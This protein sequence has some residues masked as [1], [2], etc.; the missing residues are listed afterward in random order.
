MAAALRTA[1]NR[2]AASRTAKTRQPLRG[3]RRHGSRFADCEDPAAASRT[4]RTRQPL[5]GLHKSKVQNIN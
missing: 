4:A 1:E 2:A 5:R 3:L